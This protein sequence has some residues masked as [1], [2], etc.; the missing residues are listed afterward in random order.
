MTGIAGGP[1]AWWEWGGGGGGP[2]VGLGKGGEFCDRPGAVHITF[3][4]GGGCA[5]GA[6][7]ESCGVCR[8][9]VGELGIF[10][11]SSTGNFTKNIVSDYSCSFDIIP[12]KNRIPK[13]AFFIVSLCNFYAFIHLIPCNKIWGPKY[14]HPNIFLPIH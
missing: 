14:N 2:V 12:F 9:G 10:T 7:E 1:V 13:T 6:G 11:P 4:E 8:E 3:N 5:G